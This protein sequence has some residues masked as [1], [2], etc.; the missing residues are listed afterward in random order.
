LEL[1]DDVPP[2]P[3]DQDGVLRSRPVP[4]GLTVHDGWVRVVDLATG[5]LVPTPKESEQRR[6][7]AEREAR[8]SLS[9][10]WEADSLAKVAVERAQ[11]AEARASALEAELERLRRLLNDRNTDRD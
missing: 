11:A 8:E 10:A 9:R 2:E 3:A 1:G 4:F 7:Q 6:L 5:E